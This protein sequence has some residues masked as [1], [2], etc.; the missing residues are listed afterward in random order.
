MLSIHSVHE[1]ITVAGESKARPPMVATNVYLRTGERLAY[2]RPP[3]LARARGAAPA[4]RR[5][6]EDA[7]LSGRASHAS[8]AGWQRT[9]RIPRARPQAAAIRA[10]SRAVVAARRQRADDLRVALRP[11]PRGPLAPRALGHARRRFRRRRFRRR[12]G[13]TRR[14]VLFHGLEGG[15]RSHYARAHRSRRASAAA[16]A[17]RCCISAAAAAS[18][19]ACRAP[20]TR[21]TRDEIDWML[22]RLARRS[23]RAPRL[24]GGVSL[25]GNALLKWLGERGAGARP[26]CAPRPRSRRRST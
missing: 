17:Q 26:W 6:P 22:R 2:A 1:N 3:C 20:T 16:G 12:P 25:G 13:R 5:R 21:A 8:D 10:L 18:P 7:A 11:R 4:A 24:R 15:S 9:R 23:A 19:T 14:W